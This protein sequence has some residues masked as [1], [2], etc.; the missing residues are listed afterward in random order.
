MGDLPEDLT[1][2]QKALAA[3][4]ERLLGAVGEVTASLSDWLKL[5]LP[6]SVLVVDDEVGDCDLIGQLLRRIQG[7]VVVCTHTFTEARKAIGQQDFAV[8]LLDMHLPDGNGWELARLV[9][10]TSAVVLMSGVVPPDELEMVR[11]RTRA[12][13]IVELFDLPKLVR[14]VERLL[15][16]DQGSIG[17]LQSGS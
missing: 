16:P 12:Q 8:V 17:S 6:R 9:P 11:D 15:P 4:R 5:S 1:E 7:V 14:V 13:A 3:A 10:R 2:A